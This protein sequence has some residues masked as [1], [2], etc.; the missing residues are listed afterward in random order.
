MEIPDVLAETF[1]AEYARVVASVL[2]IVRDIDVAE[3]VVQDAFAQALDHW[4]AT[5]APDRPGAWLLTTAR[6]RALDRLRRDRRA[7]AR[8]DALSY[9]TLLGAMDDDGDVATPETIPDDRLRLI[10][11]CCHPALPADSR[12]ALTLRLVGGLTTPEIARAFLVPEPT[13]AQR[14]VRAK[15]AIR[16]RAL[17]YEVPAAAELPARL[18]AVLAVIYLVFNEGYA[19]HS[20]EALVR[21]DL[22]AEALRLGHMLDELMP[23][24]AEVLGLLA[25]MELHASRATTRTDAGGNL[26]LLA[27]QDRSRW[28]RARIARGVASLE[29]AGPIERAGPY[30]IQAAIAACHARAASWEATD[31]PRIVALYDTLADVAPSPVVELN[32]AAAIGMAHGPAAGLAALDGLDAD[33]LRDYHLLPAARAEFL[34]RLGRW[35]DA[36][37]EYRAALRLADNARE[38]A[39]LASRLAECE[40]RGSAP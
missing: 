8:A 1:R 36:A 21:H 16:D 5:G 3:E 19:A 24:E 20:G 2:R 25:L 11:T 32:R 33:P 31:W 7:G 26:V 12:V 39:F 10:F 4:P 14:L 17:P 6:R 9:E 18:P 38:R 40:A 13:V 23:G 34:R 15:R 37:A 35:K 30:Q 22:C 29:R 27:D 28:D